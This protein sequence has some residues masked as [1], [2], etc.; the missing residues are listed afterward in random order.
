MLF[1]LITTKKEKAQAEAARIATIKAA[2]AQRQRELGETLFTR[3]NSAASQNTVYNQ[4][5]DGRTPEGI[6][7]MR[8]EKREN[9]G[10]HYTVLVSIDDSTCNTYGGFNTPGYPIVQVDVNAKEDN[11]HV[12]Q[13]PYGPDIDFPLSSFDQTTKDLANMVKDYRL[14]N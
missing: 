1:G 11:V 12:F 7:P 3:L 10:G 5:K 14:F 2:N 9:N 13:C 4:F 8:V 6:G